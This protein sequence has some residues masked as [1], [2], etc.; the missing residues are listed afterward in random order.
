MQPPGRA[1]K[2]LTAGR[3]VKVF[4]LLF[5]RFL[6]HFVFAQMTDGERLEFTVVEIQ[7]ELFWPIVAGVRALQGVA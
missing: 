6:R 3:P 5:R 4:R 1:L 2:A 7:A